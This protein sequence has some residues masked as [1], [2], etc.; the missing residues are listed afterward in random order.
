LFL[1]H[2]L[3]LSITIDYKENLQKRTVI[4]MKKYK[5]IYILPEK[6]TNAAKKAAL[7]FLLDH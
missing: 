6:N 5:K 7:V 1:F 3:L 2:N 4:L